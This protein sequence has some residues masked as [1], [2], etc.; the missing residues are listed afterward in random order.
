MGEST[1]GTMDILAEIPGPEPFQDYVI[2]SF[3]PQKN[4]VY[5]VQIQ[6]CTDSQLICLR[7]SW[8]IERIAC[9]S[10]QR[11][12]L[13]EVLVQNCLPHL[14]LRRPLASPFFKLFESLQTQDLYTR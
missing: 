6:S 8:Y 5:A 7:T 3:H 1:A 14:L 13:R 11:K 2:A 10:I 4:I 9:T 12:P